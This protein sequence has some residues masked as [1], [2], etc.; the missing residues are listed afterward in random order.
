MRNY[1]N[2]ANL[3]FYLSIYI[4]NFNCIYI[5]LNAL[6]FDL[7]T[8][9]LHGD[10]KFIILTDCIKFRFVY[11]MKLQVFLLL[12]FFFPYVFTFLC[13]TSLSVFTVLLSPMC[14]EVASLSL[15]LFYD[16]KTSRGEAK[17]L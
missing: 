13:C 10:F 11:I 12:R 15:L 9:F 8:L 17:E 7:F 2:V 5:S 14:P 16:R 1:H 6:L 4:N 3:L